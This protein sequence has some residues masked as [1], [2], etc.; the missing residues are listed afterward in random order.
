MHAI[1]K[2]PQTVDIRDSTPPS[3]TRLSW[4]RQVVSAK[5][6]L[7]EQLDSPWTSLR[8]IAEV[9]DVPRSTLRTWRQQKQQLLQHS[10]WATE[11]VEFF[12]SPA[13]LS[14]LHQMLAAGRSSGLWTSQRRWNPQPLCVLGNERA[15]AFRCRFVRLSTS[16]RRG[17]G[18]P[19][20]PVRPGR[21]SAAGRPNATS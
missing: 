21:R 14:F 6:E 4:P 10:G 2:C 11:V 1:E 9:L 7:A 5:Q 20:R 13:G 15:A 12:E 17:N 18:K 19:N 16:S 8:E 3:S